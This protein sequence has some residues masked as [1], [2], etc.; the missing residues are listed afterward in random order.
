[1]AACTDDDHIKS[2][3][4]PTMTTGPTQ[5]LPDTLSFIL[6]RKRVHPKATMAPMSTSKMS[7]VDMAVS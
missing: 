3:T 6:P 2:S 1:M 5:C 4:K 7:P